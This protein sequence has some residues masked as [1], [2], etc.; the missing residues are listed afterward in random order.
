[1]RST[2]EENR[3]HDFE[4]LEQKLA[5]VRDELRV[6]LHLAR[7]DARDE[8][9]GLETKW[10]RFRTHLG[11]VRAAS[12]EMGEEVREGLRTLGH[13]IGEGYERIRRTL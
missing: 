7:A 4:T 11:A 13:E 2:I 6:R 1:M 10:Q 3:V 12:G 8:W 9:E 5:Q